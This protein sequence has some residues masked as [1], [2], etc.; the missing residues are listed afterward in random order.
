MEVRMSKPKVTVRAT[1]RLHK[2]PQ[3]LLGNERVRIPDDIQPD[4]R[5]EEMARIVRSAPKEELDKIVKS[6]KKIR[7]NKRKE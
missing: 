2:K 6:A 7:K 1:S 4:E 5:F 3:P